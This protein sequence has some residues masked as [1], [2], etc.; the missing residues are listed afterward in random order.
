LGTV[1]DTPLV[2]ARLRE[3][4]RL[5]FEARATHPVPA[6]LPAPPAT[7]AAPYKKLAEDHDL[8]WLSVAEV[9]DGARAFV[10]PL[11][12]D[13]ELVTWDPAAWTWR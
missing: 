4:L 7:W 6:A 5:T 1:K 11:L 9:T 13:R 12:S 10:D 8:P 3:A 2:P